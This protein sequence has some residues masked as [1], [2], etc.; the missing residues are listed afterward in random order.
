MLVLSRKKNESIV[1]DG[2]ITIEILQVKGKGVRLGIK[3]PQDVRVLRGELKI[4]EE[5]SGSLTSLVNASAARVSVPMSA[6][7]A[8]GLSEKGR[9]LFV[10]T[11]DGDLR[12]D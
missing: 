6:Q 2:N 10:E 3:A 12:N 7:S 5:T 1:I 11:N 4:F 8:K 9:R